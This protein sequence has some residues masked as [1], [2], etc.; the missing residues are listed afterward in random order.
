MTP[1]LASDATNG[2]KNSGTIAFGGIPAAQTS[3]V[4]R[5]SKEWI[6]GRLLTPITLSSDPRSGMIRA[7]R[8]P[9]VRSVGMSAH[10]HNDGLLID[11]AYSTAAG[12]IDLSKDFYPFGE[13]PK[14]N[15]TLWLAMEEAFSN[16][17]ATV[18]LDVEVDQSARFGPCSFPAATPSDGLKLRWEVWN[19][20]WVELG[21]STNNGPA[22]PIVN[23]RAFSDTTNAF[24]QSGKVGFVLPPT[25]PYSA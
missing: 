8:L 22:Q 5:V 20:Q 19:G 15:D 7:G 17:G 4:G 16:A 24:S 21:T 11:E 25:S 10:L 23:G 2:L 12:L 6:R 14:F 9:V 3:S 13:K 1:S 18:T